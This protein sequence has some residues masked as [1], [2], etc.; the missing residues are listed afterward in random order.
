M[1]QVATTLIRAET[2]A[3]IA[4]P[5]FVRLLPD[6]ADA[7]GQLRFLGLSRWRKQ[8]RQSLRKLRDGDSVITGLLSVQVQ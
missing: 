3:G 6:Y 5:K 7:I 1:T 8:I 2:V 4:S